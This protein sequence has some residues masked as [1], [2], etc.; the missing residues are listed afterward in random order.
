MTMEGQ[1][2]PWHVHCEPCEQVGMCLD[3]SLQTSLLI[4]SELTT[5]LGDLFLFYTELERACLFNGFD[6]VVIIDLGIKD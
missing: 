6:I 1:I 5:E 3:H 2:N 4:L